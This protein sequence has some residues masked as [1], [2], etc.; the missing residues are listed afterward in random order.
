MSK[1]IIIVMPAHNVELTLE[2][3]YQ[4]IPKGLINEVILCD[5]DSKEGSRRRLTFL[6]A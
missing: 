1:K 6:A 3:T 2:K 4:E 5:D